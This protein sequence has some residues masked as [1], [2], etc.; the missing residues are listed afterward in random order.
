MKLVELGIVEPV[1][2]S[3]PTTWS[4]PLH[5][6]PKGPGKWRPCGDFRLVNKK[7]LL[8]TYNLPNVKTFSQEVRGSK[9]SKVDLTKAYHHVPIAEKDRH[10]TAVLTPWGAYQFRMMAMGLSSA[11]QTFQRLLDHVL[12]DVPNI[13]IYLDDVLIFTETEEEHEQVV[14]VVLQRLDQAG[15]T[16][17]LDK[18]R[19]GKPEIEFL[20]FK[21]NQNGVSPIEHKLSAIKGCAPP[22][23]QRKLRVFLGAISYYRHCLPLIAINNRKV[24]AAEVLQP[25]YK[26]A[27]TKLPIKI[28][29]KT[30][31]ANDPNLQKS[32]QNAKDLL[33]NTCVLTSE[34]FDTIVSVS[35][36]RDFW[37]KVS[38]RYRN[39]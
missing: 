28:S 18:C 1:D 4:S 3:Q 34:P 37:R 35:K 17:A 39:L 10:K 12:K 2:L 20:G 22:E 36:L 19:F 9:V 32:F 23:T 15:L 31:W 8:D 29:F 27:T 24:N 33:T 6:Q 38:Y 11:G 30:F 25:L 5:L 21:V 16:L 13:F 26:A 7:T 14:K